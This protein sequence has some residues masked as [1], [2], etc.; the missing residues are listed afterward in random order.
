MQAILI[1]FIFLSTEMA[2]GLGGTI[3]GS[4]E[5]PGP[6]RPAFLNEFTDTFYRFNVFDPFLME[7]GLRYRDP[8]Y[9][10][11]L[12]VDVAKIK[13]AQDVGYIRSYSIKDSFQLYKKLEQNA[14]SFGPDTLAKI[15]DF[16]R[17]QLDNIYAEKNCYR[18]IYA[19]GKVSPLNSEYIAAIP[20]NLG[21]CD[22]FLAVLDIIQAFRMIENTMENS[23]GILP[24]IH[25]ELKK[26]LVDAALGMLK[27]EAN[28]R[29]DN[30]FN[31][32]RI[33]LAL[34]DIDFT[35]SLTLLA[36]GFQAPASLRIDILTIAAPEQ[37][38]YPYAKASYNERKKFL[39][40]LF[41]NPAKALPLTLSS[42]DLAK[43][44][45]PR[46]NE[47]QFAE[48]QNWAIEQGYIK[49]IN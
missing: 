49:V 38:V 35:L 30:A 21:H 39:Q 12:S 24:T 13:A 1:A 7:T 6:D 16:H 29:K 10:Q 46:A 40:Y 47:T 27:N 41:T 37:T 2:F 43:S 32:K 19:N 33:S 15:L 44:R 5:N 34:I 28:Y 20:E 26:F 11:V 25:P 23:Q 3:I 45:G 4:H 36:S 22:Y 14:G 9:R 48:F 31:D 42:K 8:E 18:F 17:A